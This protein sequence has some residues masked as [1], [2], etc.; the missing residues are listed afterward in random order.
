M[1]IKTLLN[2]DDTITMTQKT[3]GREKNQKKETNADDYKTEKPQHENDKT[4]C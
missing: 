3:S 2:H 4:D 1:K